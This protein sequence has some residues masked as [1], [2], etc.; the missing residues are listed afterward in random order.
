MVDVANRAYVDVRL[1]TF[2]FGFGH[3]AIPRKMSKFGQVFRIEML[4][5]D[6]I[7]IWKIGSGRLEP[8]IGIEPMTSPLPRVC[9]TI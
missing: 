2:E 7:S 5:R 9:S 4:S 1:L 3:E 8:M 6:R